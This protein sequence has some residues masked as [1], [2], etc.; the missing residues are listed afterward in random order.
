MTKE[1]TPRVEEKGMNQKSEDLLQVY[2]TLSFDVPLASMRWIFGSGNDKESTLAI[3]KGYDAGVRLATSAVDSLYR[4]QSLSEVLGTTVN[5]MLRIQQFTNAAS[6][7]F[8][9]G[10]WQ[11]L[12]LTATSEG[13]P[14]AEALEVSR[15]EPTRTPTPATTVRRSRKHQIRTHEPVLTPAYR[16]PQSSEL[17]AA[18]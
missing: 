5:Q 17:R 16:L 6:K 18:A 10:L 4:S 12:A 14:I 3:W 13:Q 11:P 8:V 15:R 2:K 1:I 7:L 9:T